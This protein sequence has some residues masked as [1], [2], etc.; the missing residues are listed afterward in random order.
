MAVSLKPSALEPLSCFQ[1]CHFNKLKEYPNSDDMMGRF[2]RTGFVWVRHVNNS[3]NI[4]PRRR[5]VTGRYMWAQ[6]AEPSTEPF[7]NFLKQPP[8]TQNR[9]RPW[10]QRRELFGEHSEEPFW[11]AKAICC[12]EPFCPETFTRAEDQSW[13]CW[14]LTLLGKNAPKELRN[15]ETSLKKLWGN[16][17]QNL[18]APQNGSVPEDQRHHETCATLSKPWWNLAKALV[19]PWRNL[20]KILVEP[21]AEPS[22][23]P[24]RI[25]PREP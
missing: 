13:R 17:R 6:L 19:E 8:F 16:L 23:G 2:L 21:F 20:P 1:V 14:P 22:G 11:E 4:D 3:G 7:L 18:L 24:R 25:W 12:K 5:L 15:W 10:D 9:R